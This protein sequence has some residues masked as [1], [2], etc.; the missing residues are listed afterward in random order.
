MAKTLKKLN[1]LERNT[2]TA[3]PAPKRSKSSSD[4]CE[5]VTTMGK[6]TTLGRLRRASARQRAEK[7]RPDLRRRFFA[8][9]S[10]AERD[11]CSRGDR[12]TGHPNAKVRR[13]PRQPL[14]AR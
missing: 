5:P 9:K 12:G 13:R 2:V 14:K 10:E 7:L 4:G 6:R 1:A 3:C 11:L 8:G